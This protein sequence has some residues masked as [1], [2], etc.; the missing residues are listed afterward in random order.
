MSTFDSSKYLADGRATS[1]PFSTQAHNCGRTPASSSSTNDIS[2]DHRESS[3][4]DLINSSY[5]FTSHLNSSDKQTTS[6]STVRSQRKLTRRSLES[7]TMRRCGTPQN[8]YMNRLSNSVNVMGYVSGSVWEAIDFTPLPEH[9]DKH[10]DEVVSNN[11]VT[12]ETIK[13]S[14]I[15]KVSQMNIQHEKTPLNISNNTPTAK[16]SVNVT[17]QGKD[18]ENKLKTN[19]ETPFSRNETKLPKRRSRLRKLQSKNIKTTNIMKNIDEFIELDNKENETEGVSDSNNGD[20]LEKVATE[21]EDNEIEQSSPQDICSAKKKS[22]K[23]HFNCTGLSEI[24]NL[25]QNMTV[26]AEDISIDNRRD[27]TIFTPKIT[28]VNSSVTSSTD[29]IFDAT[30]IGESEVSYVALESSQQFITTVGFV[31]PDNFPER[32]VKEDIRPSQPASRPRQPI[33]SSLGPIGMPIL[34]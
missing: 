27:I 33:R 16:Q 12:S 9:V 4:E 28:S 3:V 20:H 26:K 2:S 29:K 25:M 34:R 30:T 14:F 17:T 18:K 15:E 13:E 1:T 8:Q 31:H 24:N 11:N 6:S 32:L 23:S 7:S 21:F 22:R 19:Y 5:S 10:F